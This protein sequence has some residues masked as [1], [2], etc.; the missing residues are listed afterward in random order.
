MAIVKD[1]ERLKKPTEK[2]KEGQDISYCVGALFRGLKE[3]NALGLAANQ[4]GFNYRILVLKV[5]GRSPVCLINP[6]ITKQRGSQIAQEQCLSLPGLVVTVKRPRQ[7]VVRGLNQYL[8]PVKYRFNGFNAR[9]ACH[10]IDHLEGKLITD[11]RR[12]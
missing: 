7:I 1:I 11:Y 2:V 9:K 5:E 12:P 3:Y 6:V 10:E 8:R 4:L